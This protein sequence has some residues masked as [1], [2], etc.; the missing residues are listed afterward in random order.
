MHMKDLLRP[1]FE[2]LEQCARSPELNPN[3]EK[4]NQDYL[5]AIALLSQKKL[6]ELKVLLEQLNQQNKKNVTEQD[7]KPLLDFISS[8]VA[9]A[10]DTPLNFNYRRW[11]IN[12]V[13]RKLCES[14]APLVN[15]HPLQLMFPQLVLTEELKQYKLGELHQVVISDDKRTLI[16]VGQCLQNAALGLA[17]SGQMELKHTHPVAG[18]TELTGAEKWRVKR[19]TPEATA[20]HDAIERKQPKEDCE[21]AYQLYRSKLNEAALFL[22]YEKAGRDKIF[23]ALHEG[24][25]NR[26]G[27]IAAMQIFT[28]KQLRDEFLQTFTPAELFELVL[29]NGKNGF[30]RKLFEAILK[31]DETYQWTAENTHD[32]C[33][34]YLFGFAYKVYTANR[35]TQS[36]SMFGGGVSKDDK[37]KAI[38]AHLERLASEARFGN[39]YKFRKND[40]FK[41]NSTAFN[42]GLLSVI[43]SQAV[44]VSLPEKNRPTPQQEAPAASRGWFGF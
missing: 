13:V 32:E 18:K 17:N 14:L 6:A 38:N 3:E 5:N 22:G 41:S 33:A 29:E 25:K 15:K 36:L 26:E 16:D 21:K 19:H 40:V 44:K 24:I 35:Q 43:Q 39:L 10:Q 7:V 11:H 37:L 30:D 28:A 12:R 27:L 2:T 9:I 20:L 23:A 31:A 1:V 42:D 34:S 8:Y 4:D